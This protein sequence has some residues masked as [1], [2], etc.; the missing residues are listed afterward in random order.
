MVDIYISTDPKAYRLIGWRFAYHAD[1]RMR[2]RQFLD[3]EIAFVIAFGEET[4][5]GDGKRYYHLLQKCLPARYW[6]IKWISHLNGLLVVT[7][8]SKQVIVTM[9]H[10]RKREEIWWPK[11][12]RNQ[13]A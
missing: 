8:A 13:A 11:R 2:R 5:N 4:Y 3:E 10:D 1:Q 7:E 12:Q 9:Y 6:R